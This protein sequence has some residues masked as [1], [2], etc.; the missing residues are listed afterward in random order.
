MNTDETPPKPGS[1]AIYVY[2]EKSGMY[3]VYQLMTNTWGSHEKHTPEE[4]QSI[5]GIKIHAP[6]G[7]RTMPPEERHRTG[8]LD[9]LEN[10]EVP[11]TRAEFERRAIISEASWPDEIASLPGSS[12]AP[13]DPSSEEGAG[14]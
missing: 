1:D 6:D 5:T 7:W 4:W 2:D 10:W 9:G 3:G 12:P 8:R 14:H 13:H 11:I